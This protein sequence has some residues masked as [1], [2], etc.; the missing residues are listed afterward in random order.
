[1]DSQQLARNPWLNLIDTVKAAAK[2]CLLVISL[3][4]NPIQVIV[5]KAQVLFKNSK[6]I[7]HWICTV[8]SKKRLRM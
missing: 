8:E 4:R 6:S 7:R 1:M 5:Q 3:I 2:F